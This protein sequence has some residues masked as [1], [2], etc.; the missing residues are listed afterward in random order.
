MSP[1]DRADMNNTVYLV[2]PTEPFVRRRRR[3]IIQLLWI[4]IMGR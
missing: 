1:K 3:N 4:Y 2:G